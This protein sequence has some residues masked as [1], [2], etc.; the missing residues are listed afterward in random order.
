MLASSLRETC[1]SYPGDGQY[2][3]PKVVS[4]IRWAAFASQGLTPASLGR[5]P[6]TPNND[7][8]RPPNV[9]LQ[10]LA[11]AAESI[12]SLLQTIS[13]ARQCGRNRGDMFSHALPLTCNRRPGMKDLARRLDR[14]TAPLAIDLRSD[15]Y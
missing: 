6:R 14:V 5:S 10:I 8:G 13:D 9:L 3:R 4:A 1:P 2:R 7:A 15:A 11:A 12:E